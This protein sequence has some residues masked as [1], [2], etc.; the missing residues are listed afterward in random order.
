MWGNDA[1]SITEVK[2]MSFKQETLNKV[3]NYEVGDPRRIYVSFEDWVNDELVYRKGT[4]VG[5]IK[6]PIWIC[7]TFGTEYQC[8]D[9]YIIITRSRERV[10]VHSYIPSNNK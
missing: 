4:L 5:V 10:Q 6:G 2:K 9:T 8:E 7:P 1:P 3:E